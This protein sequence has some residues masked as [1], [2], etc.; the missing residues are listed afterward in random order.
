[1]RR[2]L[3]C[4]FIVAIAAVA[5][6]AKVDGRLASIKKAFV[7]PEDDLGVDKPVAACLAEHLSSLLPI[8]SVATK[9]D[10]EVVFKVRANL[11]SA[12]SRVMLGGMG[13]SP[14]AF[15]TV[16][17]LD[18]KKLWADGAKLRRAIGKFGKLETADGT[19]GVECGLADELLGTLRDAMREARGKK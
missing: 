13:G 16:E 18:G 11:P 17:L 8:E 14:S 10:A 9:D 12:T 4:G 3:L 15:L 19:K 5:L 1:M 7:V 6:A 2:T